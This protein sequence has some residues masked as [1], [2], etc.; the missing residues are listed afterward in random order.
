M[1]N[2]KKAFNFKHGVQVDVDNF[3]VSAGGN[4][5]IGTTRPRQLLD[6]YGT[7][8]VNGLTTTTT[9]T[10][11]GDSQFNSDVK[12]GTAVTIS[13]GI[14]TATSYYGDGTKLS[15][16]VGYH[17][18][19]WNLGAVGLTTTTPV[20]VGTDTAIASY[21][22]VVGGDPNSTS[23]IS[24][25]KEGN[26]KSSGII[27]AT[28]GFIGTVRASDLT[29]TISDDRLPDTITSNITGN[30]TGT[31][32]SATVAD[33]LQNT[34]DINVGLLTATNIVGTSLSI[35]GNLHLTGTA[36]SIGIGTN[37]PTTDLQ[38]RRSGNAVLEV[39]SDTDKAKIGLG[40]SLG[41]GNSSAEI[42]FHDKN[43]EFYNYD[44][45]NIDTIIHD[46]TGAG[47]TGSF[48][49]LY[50][51]ESPNSVLLK[52]THDGKL[53]INV[54][55]LVSGYNLQ[56]SGGS[57]IT[58]SSYFGN[59]V[60]IEGAVSVGS[61]NLPDVISG[62][63]LTV[64]EGISTFNNINA[65]GSASTISTLTVTTLKAS[66]FDAVGVT[67]IIQSSTIAVPVLNN[68]EQTGLT[69]IT[70]SIILNSNDGKFRGWTGTAWVDF[71]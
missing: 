26:L 12:I 16:I 50:G 61:I 67:S 34:P 30:L 17:T 29:G 47:T 6:V 51:Q 42:R 11:T 48:R 71:H 7:A 32:S 8:R 3:V 53:G 66:N 49:W 68:S 35:T 69:T 63:N 22:L 23:G 55:N 25:V 65:T 5:G 44:T 36:T 59:N 52:L 28:G 14:V 64:T 2:H 40:N 24:L 19:A 56:V 27:T 4:V 58:G 15:G 45:G 37:I 43:L 54:S 31:A 10:V 21:D 62:T 39:V 1:A 46:G 18:T 41:I 33:G 20:G 70:G 60:T 38:I 57:S 9:L 13:N